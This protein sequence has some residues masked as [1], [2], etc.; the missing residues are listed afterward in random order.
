MAKGAKRVNLSFL[1]GAFAEEW[2]PPRA[3]S[4][5]GE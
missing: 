3:Q 4:D 2:G 1:C 5:P